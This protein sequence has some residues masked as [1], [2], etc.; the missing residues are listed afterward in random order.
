MLFF[1]TITI[2][3]KKLARMQSTLFTILLST[4]VTVV[5]YSQIVIG[6]DTLVGNEW[7]DY[8]QS[9]YKMT[10]AE[11]GLYR[12]TYEELLAAG[13]P[14]QSLTGADLQLY[15]FGQEQSIHVST[16]GE[17]TSEDY[18]EFV[19][20]K[21]RGEFDKY[22][23]N[24]QEDPLNPM[25]SL[26]SDTS[27][28]FLSWEQG[29]NHKRFQEELV[30]L[31]NNTLS[32]EP[33]YMHEDVLIF[34]NRVNKPSEAQDV[35][36]SQFL[37]GEGFSGNLNTINQFQHK[38]GSKYENGPAPSLD[39]RLSGNNLLH[40]IDV[41]VNDNVKFTASFQQKETKQY[42]INL[43]ESDLGNGDA[44][45]EVR[46]Y[47][48]TAD[49]NTIANSVLRYART[50][51]FENNSE[52]QIKIEPSSQDRYFEFSNL[53][54]SSEITIIDVTNGI[55]YTPEIEDAMVKLILPASNS[56][57]VLKIVNTSAIKQI[58]TI[59]NVTMVDYSEMSDA[60]FV[61]Y[62]S[63]VFDKESSDGVNYLRAYAEHRASINGGSLVSAVVFVED[64][65]NQ[66]GYGISRHPLAIKNHARWV[67]ANWTSA[68]YNFIIGKALEYASSRT[69]D[70]LNDPDPLKLK[71]YVPTFGM[72]GSDNTLFAKKNQSQPRVPTGRISVT[73]IDDIEAYY[74]K[75]VTRENPATYPSNIEGRLWT[76]NI[77][78]L[79]GGDETIL[80][81]IESSLESMGNILVQSRFGAKVKTFTKQSSDNI[82]TGFA[83]QVLEKV[84]EGASIISFFGHSSPG[85][86][87]FALEKASQYANEGKLPLFLSMGCYSGNIHTGGKSISEDFVLE[88]KVGSIVFMA[89]AGSAYITPQG[90]LG[91]AF[92]QAV[93]NDQFYGGTVG[94]V[95][96][97]LL[98]ANNTTPNTNI[99]LRT[100]NEQFTLHGDPAVRITTFVGPDYTIDYSSVSTNPTIVSPENK[101]FD[102]IYKVANLGENINDSINVRAIQ[103]LPDGT[104]YDTLYRRIAGPAH[105]QLDTFTF[106]NPGIIGIGENCLTIELNYDGEIDEKPSPDAIANNVLGY[107]EGEGNFCYFALD[108]SANPI[109]P[110]D[111]A[112]V[113]GEQPRLIASTSNLLAG[114]KTYIMEIDTTSLFNSTIKET[115]IIE[116]GGGSLIWQ[117]QSELIPGEVYY[118]RVSADS[119][120]VNIGFQWRESSFIYLPNS[121]DG[122]NQSH[123]YQFL[124]NDLTGIDFKDRKLDFINE[125]ISIYANIFIPQ[126][127][128]DVVPRW[129]EN[130]FTP[131]QLRTWDL[132]QDGIAVAMR[133]NG[134][135]VWIRNQSLGGSVG[136]YGSFYRGSTRRVFFFPTDNQESR[137]A[138][139]NMLEDSVPE[140]YH[141]F[142]W[143]VTN[144]TES[145][146]NVDEWAL[147]SLNNNGKNLFN[148]LEK[149][150]ATLARSI[151]ER[152]TVPYGIIY[153]KNEEL[154]DESIGLD[155][156]SEIN[157]SGEFERN[158]IEGDLNTPNIGP[159]LAW[160][161][162][163]WSVEDQSEN[164]SYMLYI[165]GIKE[166]GE[167]DTLYTIVNETEVDLSAVDAEVYPYL[168][169]DMYTMDDVDRTP[170]N[171]KFWR[172]FYD[173]APEAILNKDNTFVFNSDTLQQGQL[174]EFAIKAENISSNDMD[175][176]LVK[177]TITNAVNESIVKYD[178]LA[179]LKSN[180]TQLLNF[181]YDTKS[182][183]GDHQFNFEINPEG[184]QKEKFLFN[185]FGVTDFHVSTDEEQPILDV[186]FDGVHIINGD[187]VAANPFILI[188]VRDENEFLL[189]DNPE[190]IMVS[191]IDPSGNT[192]DYN[193]SSPELSF[194]PATDVNNNQARI[195]LEP[196]LTQDGDYTLVVQAFDASDNISGVNAYEVSF[197][198]ILQESVSNVL[199]YPNP[200]SSQTQFIFTLTGSQVPDNISI[201]ILTVSGKVVKEISRE[202]LGPLRIG[203]N[204][205][206]YK[207]N[208]TDDYGEKLANGVY[209]YKV[210]T[211]VD[212][213]RYENDAADKFFTKGFGKLVIMR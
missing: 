15:Y 131:G 49:K 195:S 21:N 124:K 95:L 39:I 68:K 77:V 8:D 180:E 48:S 156:F 171:L 121:S 69:E 32:A 192:V 177:Y 161:R 42:S 172:V 144:S 30:D 63:K 166:N 155:R 173:A 108:N 17:L 115:N 202:E 200:F 4:L 178:R 208:G 116:E 163:T 24:N 129:Y 176:L 76:K 193:I 59:E 20:V 36:F 9:Y 118:W 207:W 65:Y 91:E 135:N 50:F 47:H 43:E 100:L 66:F 74:D 46:S 142:V 133:D 138:L 139:V 5:T 141:T 82:E 209:L 211:P 126:V 78:H 164:D 160:D 97:H 92:Y 86:L 88:P 104:P 40:T 159:A 175:S 61:M 57:S 109:F 136:Q 206:D 34:N 201:S 150:G 35:R 11:D 45:I 81:L 145:D 26:F 13:I 153:T 152:G 179:P 80:D 119:T 83:A 197:R 186:S 38:V 101:E 79:A 3:M 120:D 199:N 122:W 31:T 85:T 130:T 162:M 191:L 168:R 149:Q 213:E 198:V 123:Y 107:S 12:V 167:M 22:L 203:L 189:L 190:K 128:A 194:E 158:Y 89:S 14:L 52:T 87:D 127:A 7:I 99:S 23:Y 165:K 51:D 56:T 182:L 10:L 71:F 188:D 29:I 73:S 181:T 72:P 169:L 170:V 143:T 33:Y 132:S 140:G 185:N 27:A 117:P 60:E 37:P 19:G 54:I 205:T 2:T 212:M 64:L 111:F 103:F 53:D 28:Y 94:D 18:I 196:V 55:K 105:S 112:I 70:Q 16:D 84:N 90:N 204:R 134:I 187:I 96:N 6:Q 67:D 25:Y 174:M 114:N 44:S 1:S 210:N 147:D 62:S 102:V 151:Q 125:G 113:N 157:L 93:S 75:V 110:E 183:Q 58:A 98:A 137:I 154:K 41:S 106:T 148:V 146:L 184:D